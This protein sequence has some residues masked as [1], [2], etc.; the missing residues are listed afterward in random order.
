MA[1]RQQ[2][3]R[4]TAG[5]EI[6]DKDL[7][8]DVVG[9]LQHHRQAATYGA[10]SGVVGGTPQSVM[11]DE[12]RSF[13]NSWIV[14][15]DTRRPIG[16]EAG[17]IHPE[18]LASIEA[19]GVIETPEQLSKWLSSHRKLV[20]RDDWERRLLAIGTDCGTSL[21]PGSWTSDEMYD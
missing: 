21:P 16:Y 6:V 17:Q 13:R 15:E 18:L 1:T 10:L 19:H 7:L 5:V 4:Q 11:A 2:G 14:C 12:P 3:L 20:P 9:W 8:R